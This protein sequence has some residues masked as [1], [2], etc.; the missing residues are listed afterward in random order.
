[1]GY[2]CKKALVWLNVYVV[3]SSHLWILAWANPYSVVDHRGGGY[4]ER[5]DMDIRYIE[6]ETGRPVTSMRLDHKINSSWFSHEETMTILYEIGIQ[7]VP[8]KKVPSPEN[9]ALEHVSNDM[10]R[11]MLAVAAGS[12]VPMILRACLEAI[13]LAMRGN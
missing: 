9:G 5:L 8:V 3:L 11:V 7:P 10:W 2:L 6:Y 12:V 13:K 4:K 1:M